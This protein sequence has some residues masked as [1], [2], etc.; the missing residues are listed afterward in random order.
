MRGKPPTTGT[1]K[2]GDRIIPA[3]AGQTNH[4]LNRTGTKT[5]HP[6]ACGAN[7]AMRVVVISGSGSSPR[8][9]GKLIR[10]LD[11]DH[12]IRI[13][14]AHAGQTI[15]LVCIYNATAGSS[16]RMRGKRDAVHCAL[17]GVRIIP[18]HAGQTSSRT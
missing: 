16:P 3:H 18:A 8:M 7:Q 9:R 17:G 14:P 10:D 2:A 5:D 12:R 4:I 15:K 6:R 13:I 1:V 11:G